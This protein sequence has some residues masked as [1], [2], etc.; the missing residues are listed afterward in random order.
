MVE[1][2]A[3][4]GMNV[5]FTRRGSVKVVLLM[6][7]GCLA[8]SAN[9]AD[10][11]VPLKS[12][13]PYGPAERVEIAGSRVLLSSGSVLKIVDVAGP[14]HPEV[15]GE[16]D[17]EMPIT[18]IAAGGLYAYVIYG[19]TGVYVINL[20]DPTDP[21]KVGDLDLDGW[22]GRIEA[23]G[24]HAYVLDDRVGFS[25]IDA[26]DPRHPELVA[27]YEPP[28]S[29]PGGDLTMTGFAYSDQRVF[30]TTIEDYPYPSLMRIVDVS[31]PSDPFEA[32]VLEIPR[33]QQP[34][35]VAAAGSRAYIE[36]YR[37]MLVADISD[38]GS[39]TVIESIEHRNQGGELEVW[40]GL[41][42]QAGGLGL[43]VYDVSV[44][45]KPSYAADSLAFTKTSDV[46]IRNGWAFVATGQDGLKVVDSR[47]PEVPE[48]IGSLDTPG[49][50]LHLAVRGDT[51]F[52]ADDG[53]D[54]R[55]IDISQPSELI[56]IG[57]L[58]LEGNA[59][60]VALDGDHAY[61]A[62]DRGGLRVVDISDPTSPE[63]IGHYLDGYRRVTTV[64]VG[65]GHAYVGSTHDTVLSVLDIGT[66]GEPVEI[67]SVSFDAPLTDVAYDQGHL[68]V[69]AS[70]AGLRIIDVSSPAAPQEISDINVS[71]GSTV[72]RVVVSGDSAYVTGSQAAVVDI[73]DR[74]HPVIVSELHFRGSAGHPTV[75]ND[76]VYIPTD[77]YGVWI[78]DVD[79]PADPEYLGFADNPGTGSA[80]AVVDDVAV[81]AASDA[82]IR[83]ID[84]GSPWTPKESG[85][86]ETPGSSELIVGS[87]HSVFVSEASGLRA[88]EDGGSSGPIEVGFCPYEI[89]NL[90]AMVLAADT[91]YLAHSGGVE[92][93]SVRDPSNPVVV[94]SIDLRH[95]ASVSV[96]Q[97]VLYA[98]ESTGDLYFYDVSDPSSPEEL[99]SYDSPGV[100]FSAVTAIR[101][102]AYLVGYTGDYRLEI[103]DVSDPSAPVRLGTYDGLENEVFGSV[104]VVG[105]TAYIAG[106]DYA[107]GWLWIVD[108]T[109]PGQAVLRGTFEG[110]YFGIRTPEVAAEGG[111]VVFT[112]PPYVFWL[113]D[114]QSP[115]NPVVLAELSDYELNRNISVDGGLLFTARGR[116]GFEIYDIRQVCE[117]PRPGGGRHTPD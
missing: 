23:D 88:Y 48:E 83:A 103:V 8:V 52:V 26:S 116:M 1:S 2:L 98:T 11:C 101:G 18:D 64:D 51:A 63:E 110:Y 113:L 24:D 86:L 84:V 4:E 43:Q 80:V 108:V 36:A 90:K 13:W 30:L 34:G 97:S 21:V 78:F 82:G 54:L 3:T 31:V 42:F 73:R 76:V 41:L 99:G 58:A 111:R 72:D 25:I 77:H 115:E 45:E 15:I 102:T 94:A 107:V 37:Q 46:A 20:S 96:D 27:T 69:A 44:S 10:E 38:A 70:Q 61:V 79:R 93:I 22:P 106:H 9:H 28:P 12:R 105:N 71:S 56:E 75:T 5:V 89:G 87:D 17:L 114:V 16:I 85:G 33:S 104:E 112:A 66:P 29:N 68:F 14:R 74:S 49:D 67:A 50:A 32:G 91:V 19:S 65:G 7:A 6:I 57:S 59:V 100:S 39:P 81:L 35:A 117:P 60:E 109:D 47:D 40:E 55:V 95:A 92:I 62:A 53:G